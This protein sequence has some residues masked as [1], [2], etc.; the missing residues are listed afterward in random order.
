MPFTD[1]TRLQGR[2][3]QEDRRLGSNGEVVAVSIKDFP[4]AQ[5]S[6]S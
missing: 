2:M 6:D 5:Q 3:C 4:V 1:I